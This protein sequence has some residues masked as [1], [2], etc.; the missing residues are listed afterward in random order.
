MNLRTQTMIHLDVARPKVKKEH[1]I[2]ALK[3]L[4]ANA[5]RMG[6]TDRA[7]GNYSL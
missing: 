4:E 6:R 1:D 7:K 3:R 5:L 2:T